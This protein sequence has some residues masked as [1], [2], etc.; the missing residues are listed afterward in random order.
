MR[1]RERNN[2]T[3]R[4]VGETTERTIDA[5]S[6]KRRKRQ[7]R[8]KK[9]ERASERER[10]KTGKKEKTL[11]RLYR[12]GRGCSERESLGRDRFAASERARE[13]RARKRTRSER[14]GGGRNGSVARIESSSLFFGRSVLR[15]PSNANR[16]VAL[17]AKKRE[18]KTTKP[19]ERRR[20]RRRE[21]V[22]REPATRNR[23]NSK[24]RK[25]S[26]ERD[27]RLVE[28]LQLWW[29]RVAACG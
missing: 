27:T 10:R 23:R 21:R 25:F 22:D 29:S 7:E 1:Y 6:V 20:E 18:S 26:A 24:R 2:A 19:N 11:C 3:S 15:R 16:A 14:D 17:R 9:S 13:A 4:P 5:R 8:E 28:P 12:S